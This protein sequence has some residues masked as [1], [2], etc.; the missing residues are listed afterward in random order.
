MRQAGLL[1]AAF[2]LASATNAQ[3]QQS[4]IQIEKLGEASY[5]LVLKSFK[6]AEVSAGQQELVP[7]AR[8]LCAD[9]S[10][11]FGKYEFEKSEP[12]RPG[13]GQV[14]SLVL[15]QEIHC[16]DIAGAPATSP[17]AAKPDPQW[18]PTAEQEKLIESVTLTYFAA[19]DQRNYSQA[20]AFLSPS[21]QAATPFESWRSEREQF[22]S[23]AGDVHSRKIKKIT[24]YKDPPQAAPGLYAA[25]DFESRFANIDIHCGYLV[26][27]QAQDRTFRLIREEE[28]LIDKEMQRKLP[29][30][31]LAAAR[32]KFGC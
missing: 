19:K 27:H 18:R 6:S 14:R 21:R 16:G 20:Y 5:R 10:I 30:A 25:A 13:A 8:R 24:W 28:N 23:R 9:K 15:K 29:P 32:A 22:H 31:E 7:T 11:R 26:W 17:A 1:I 4:E 12:L 3:S 2:I